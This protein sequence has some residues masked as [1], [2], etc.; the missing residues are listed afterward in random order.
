[1][2]YRKRGGMIK[3]YCRFLI[4]LILWAGTAYG[5]LDDLE[6]KLRRQEAV[7]LRWDNIEGSPFWV[8]G[9]HP[10]YD[11]P[12][13]LHLVVLSPQ[14]PV[15]VRLTKEAYLRIHN[16]FGCLKPDDVDVLVSNGSGLFVSQDVF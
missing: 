14:Q 1:M 7:Q 15:V 6:N 8:S 4:I 2:F 5:S 13:G 9:P 11:L 3:I 16:P 10:A 12:V